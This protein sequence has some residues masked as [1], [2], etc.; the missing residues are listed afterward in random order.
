M[1]YAILNF[2]K[3]YVFKTIKSI[4][5][6]LSNNDID[7]L[8]SNTI[9]LL[10]YLFVCS[11]L[12]ISCNNNYKLAEDIF[13]NFLIKHNNTNLKYLINLLLP[14]IK[15]NSPLN[16]IYSLS[17]III[18]KQKN[19]DINLMEPNYIYSNM[20][21]N[22]CIKENN[23]YKEIN[24]SDELIDNNLKLVINSIKLLSN[25]FHF[26]VDDIEPV[27]FSDN[28]YINNLINETK[29]KL[30][31]YNIDDPII[32]DNVFI[33]ENNKGLFVGDIYNIIRNEMFGLLSCKWLLY[34]YM[35]NDTPI[36]YIYILNKLLNLNTYIFTISYND[37]D[38]NN[39]I[40]VNNIRSN[41]KNFRNLI[42]KKYDYVI[43]SDNIIIPFN[44]LIRIHYY[45]FSCLLPHNKDEIDE[46]YNDLNNEDFDKLD[47]FIKNNDID[48]KKLIN[49]LQNKL[50]IL[51]HLCLYNNCIS[52]NI[53]KNIYVDKIYEHPKLIYNF[54]KWMITF[55][56]KSPNEW[57]R[58]N[59]EQKNIFIQK[60]L[61]QD[62]SFS[63]NNVINYYFNNLIT[64]NQVYNYNMDNLYNNII[65]CM[66]KRGILTKFKIN[67][68]K[69][70]T[71]DVYNYFT[72]QKYNHPITFYKRD[73]YNTLYQL[74]LCNHY[75]NNKI[76]YVSGST[77]IGKSTEIPK[78]F[79]YY[80]ICIHGTNNPFLFCTEPRK[81][82][83]INNA[84]Y[85][86]DNM[87]MSIKENNY[88]I[89]YHVKNNA[90]IQNDMYTNTHPTIRY[91]TD[92]LLYE[93][94]DN[95]LNDLIDSY[96]YKKI[97]KINKEYTIIIDEV[98][99]NNTYMSLLTTK[100]KQIMKKYKQL[101][102]QLIL[103][104]ATLDNEEKIYR[105]Y[106]KDIKDNDK[107]NNYEINRFYMDRR[108][109]IGVDKTNFII[110]EYFNYKLQEPY[111]DIMNL[112][113]NIL[114]YK[115]TK[116]SI[117]S[118]LD[119]LRKY[120]K[121]K[122]IIFPYFAEIRDNF[123]ELLDLLT[124]KNNIYKIKCPYDID[125]TYITETNKHILYEGNSNYQYYIIIATTIAEASITIDTLNYIIDDG[126]YNS[127]I[128]DYETRKETS[129]IQPIS[130]Y[131]RIQRK[132]RVGRTMNGTAY[133][134]YEH[135]KTLSVPVTY[136]ITEDNLTEFIL[137]LSNT[138]NRD[139]IL[140]YMGTFYVIH[141]D[142]NNLIRNI[143]GHI[144]NVKNKNICE[145]KNNKYLSKKIESFYNN[146][147]SLLLMNNNKLSNLYNI[148]I[149]ILNLFTNNIED[150]E[151]DVN[152][153]SILWII[154][155]Y[156][157]DYLDNIL[158]ILMMLNSNFSIK[159]IIN[160][161]IK[162]VNNTNIQ[163]DYDIL[164][165]F[166][167]IID[168]CSY[169]KYN[170]NLYSYN[171]IKNKNNVIID[172]IDYDDTIF[173]E[174]CNKL[175]IDTYVIKRIKNIHRTLLSI[176]LIKNVLK[177]KIEKIRI[178]DTYNIM[179]MILLLTN[180]FNVC[181][182][183][184]TNKYIFVYYGK[185]NNIIKIKSY[186]KYVHFY[187]YYF[188]DGIIIHPL[189]L[190]D[191]QK[192]TNL[193]NDINQLTINYNN[194]NRNEFIKEITTNNIHKYKNNIVNIIDQNIIELKN[195]FNKHT[196]SLIYEN[197]KK[198]II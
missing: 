63:I 196:K 64:T 85:V 173:N 174:Y 172:N 102:I 52:D 49:N 177:D 184:D 182:N 12:I 137:K 118:L 13:I 35:H 198:K 44:I 154:Y 67:N 40:Y 152:L 164:L 61:K 183:I 20:Q 197:I 109:H 195:D 82:P 194:N 22:L 117:M 144:I 176:N 78:L 65:T 189:T 147:H 73:A 38:N 68:N 146:L 28:E 50:S 84:T 59:N 43:D 90:H 181:K 79:I 142:E 159:K 131:R 139:E 80:S 66:I 5:N 91:I 185:Y 187:T 100:C 74:N 33:Y 36:T 104:S 10:K 62:Q 110:K 105:R 106:F 23:L 151:I 135:K 179:T 134:T 34:V 150:I 132:G 53:I 4:Y 71:D 155:G 95:M 188:L 160:E 153:T 86:S 24:L 51:K 76:M 119:T 93:I 143:G 130:E 1:D 17:D 25:K 129:S 192:Y 121:T 115:P 58:L 136:G 111:N 140:D 9:L 107:Y 169:I 11:N 171:E 27:L 163:S 138:Y 26:N 162:I 113:G 165:E 55:N 56:N 96:K 54:S 180:P 122:F 75:L 127:V 103:L 149:D 108:V 191:I 48:V 97:Y 92:G 57:C 161:C 32:D 29:D 145:F 70:N 31:N 186:M 168:K 141:P 42:D 156:M 77:G 89:Q 7:F 45:F 19:I 158:I 120:I 46:D 178:N 133:F 37:I 167:K 47:D 125:F 94:F 128:Y 190:N 126:E 18:A 83:T 69:T 124:K 8:A 175:H 87:N 101:R 81:D 60:L 41:I 157:F 72:K 30:I 166:N 3:R 2:D 14:F 98:H 148:Y 193:F 170:N 88:Y 21:Y 114:I 16:N 112:N 39:D 15:S 123:N 6:N 99:E 116:N